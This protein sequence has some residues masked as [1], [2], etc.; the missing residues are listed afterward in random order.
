M[1]YVQLQ[2]ASRFLPLFLSL[3]FCLSF[4][5][6]LICHTHRVSFLKRELNKS[7]SLK[8][9][10]IIPCLIFLG[11]WAIWPGVWTKSVNLPWKLQGK[12]HL[13]TAGWWLM[14][15]RRTRKVAAGCQQQRNRQ[16]RFQ[17][18]SCVTEFEGPPRRCKRLITAEEWVERRHSS[19]DL[20]WARPLGG[21]SKAGGGGSF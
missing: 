2:T 5:L 19:T 1:A 7:V 9:H 13:I 12:V 3:P 20:L 6:H 8:G 15:G 18:L 17:R 16:H 10:V 21:A 11:G 14:Q 4:P